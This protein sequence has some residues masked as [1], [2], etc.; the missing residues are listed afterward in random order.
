MLLAL[1]R[2]RP[3]TDAELPGVTELIEETPNL[4]RFIRRFMRQLYTAE[5]IQRLGLRPRNNRGLTEVELPRRLLFQR[6]I[7]MHY[8]RWAPDADVAMGMLLKPVSRF[9]Y[10]SR[11]R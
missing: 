5:E 8:N 4:A 1:V 7:G 11:R 2:A 10:E 6:L 3:V 9:L